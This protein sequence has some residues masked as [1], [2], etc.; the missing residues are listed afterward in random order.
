MLIESCSPPISSEI[1]LSSSTWNPAGI[2]SF[3]V[4]NGNRK[5]I[6]EIFSKL[7]MKKPEGRH[8][9]D[10]VLSRMQPQDVQGNIF[11][12]IWTLGWNGLTCIRCSCNICVY[13]LISGYHTESK[14]GVLKRINHE[15]YGKIY[16]WLL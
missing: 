11:V 4:S 3:Q 16:D 5:T 15:I 14:T 1:Q 6:W 8:W 12:F 13:P 2:F 10:R 9:M 7:A